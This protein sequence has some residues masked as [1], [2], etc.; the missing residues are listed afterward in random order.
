MSL[1]EVAATVAAAILARRIALY[2]ARN[3]K[4][5]RAPGQVLDYLLLKHIFSSVVHDSS[6]H[7]QARRI[8]DEMERAD[9]IGKELGNDSKPLSQQA[10]RYLQEL[11]AATERYEAPRP[12]LKIGAERHK[13]LR[14]RIE[15]I[16]HRF[17]SMEADIHLKQPV[18]AEITPLM[19]RAL[20]TARAVQDTIIGAL[21]PAFDE[22]TQRRYQRDIDRAEKRLDD[23]EQRLDR[24]QHLL[25]ADRRGEIKH[26]NSVSILMH[27]A[28][29]GNEADS[30]KLLRM[31][32]AQASDPDAAAQPLDLPLS[33][34]ALA[35]VLEEVPNKQHEAL[36]V[37]RQALA[38][39]PEEDQSLDQAEVAAD[40][41]RLAG[42]VGNFSVAKAA[43]IKAT[44]IFVA[45]GALQNARSIDE[46]AINTIRLLESTAWAED[47]K[48]E[49]R[50]VI[51]R[52]EDIERSTGRGRLPIVARAK[53][54]LIAFHI[55]Q[56]EW[57]EAEGEF[58]EFMRDRLVGFIRNPVTLQQMADM[59]HY[60]GRPMP[61]EL[62]RQLSRLVRR[63]RKN[64]FVTRFR[65]RQA[66]ERAR[67][68]A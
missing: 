10:Y 12:W 8:I 13:A 35:L 48:S 39:F 62:N 32:V 58:I 56:E 20:K 15:Q 63:R 33:L 46:V 65:A 6:T 5:R 68:L 67:L 53:A 61:P 43:S 16:G 47:T 54:E 25:A 57:A 50:G 64:G 26:P 40:V 24:A 30:L 49:F 28:A 9:A 42:R 45:H 19:E 51:R 34:S 29:R 27:L 31:A 66:R 59:I 52:A 3:H 11:I 44:D 41:A 17:Y 37:A 36:I 60:L 2:L 1:L 4:A 7:T 14:H 21:H 23:A 18:S 38:L 22:A 55:R